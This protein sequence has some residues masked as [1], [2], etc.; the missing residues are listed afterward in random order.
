MTTSTANDAQ[1]SEDWSEARHWG[2]SRFSSRAELV[3]TLFG[4]VVLVA[5]LVLAVA[6]SPGRGLVAVP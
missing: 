2:Q 5:I 3:W 6:G 1:G 4:L